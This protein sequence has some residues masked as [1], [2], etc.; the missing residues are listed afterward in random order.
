MRCVN[1]APCQGNAEPLAGMPLIE[2]Q[3]AVNEWL[4]VC[5]RCASGQPGQQ[6]L[7]VDLKTVADAV[8]VFPAFRSGRAR[9]TRP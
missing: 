7:P 2:N 4:R 8:G 9:Q 1:G 6:G 3:A 5:T